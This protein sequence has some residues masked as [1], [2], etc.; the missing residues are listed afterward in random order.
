MNSYLSAVTALHRAQYGPDTRSL[1][2]CFLLVPLSDNL[3]RAAENRT[4]AGAIGFAD[5]AFALHLIEHG[6]GAAIADAQAAL[7]DGS[8]STLHVHADAQRVFEQFVA[9]A[10]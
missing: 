10:V 4:R 1:L 6:G 2:F 5:Q 7:Q 8:R 9:L 3:K